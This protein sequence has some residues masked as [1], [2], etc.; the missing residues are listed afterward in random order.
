M[1]KVVCVFGK[2]H[3]SDEKGQAVQNATA[4]FI[5]FIW[6]SSNHAY[7]PSVRRKTVRSVCRY[8]S[9]EISYNFTI[10]CLEKSWIRIPWN[11]AVLCMIRM[12]YDILWR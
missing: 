4:D 3:A 1:R 8:G 10:V 9:P 12:T 11:A 7:S 5:Y 2:N 6:I